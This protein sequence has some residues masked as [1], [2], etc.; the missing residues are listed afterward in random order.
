MAIAECSSPWDA[1]Y[2]EANLFLVYPRRPEI[3]VNW[4][5]FERMNAWTN[6]KKELQEVD[7]KVERDLAFFRNAYFDSITR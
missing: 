3:D 5:K 4:S 1:Q 7:L 6:W 2:D